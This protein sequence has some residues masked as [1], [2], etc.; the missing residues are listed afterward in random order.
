MK[1]VEE[2]GKLEKID[3]E[4]KERRAIQRKAQTEFE[5]KQQEFK[6]KQLE[7]E[8]RILLDIGKIEEKN[9]KQKEKDTKAED[10]ARE[11][12]GKADSE[13]VKWNYLLVPFLVLQSSLKNVYSTTATTSPSL[14]VTNVVS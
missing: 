5:I 9:S 1:E 11:E 2:K 8:K 6:I 14:F 13:W 10:K 3:D 4:I 7:R 12:A